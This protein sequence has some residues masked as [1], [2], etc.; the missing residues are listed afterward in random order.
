MGN[1]QNKLSDEKKWHS[2][3][4]VDSV[5]QSGSVRSTGSLG[6]LVKEK[7]RSWGSIRS[8]GSLKGWGARRSSSKDNLDRSHGKWP[9]PL[10]EGLFLPVFPIKG[11]VD[12]TDFE[13]LGQVGQGAFGEVL[14]VVKRDS[15]KKFAMKVLSKAEI[16]RG[17]AVQ[18]CKDEVTIQWMLG[19]H[20]FIVQIFHYWQSRNSLYIVFEYMSHGEM[21]E[22]WKRE[23]R[24]SEEVTR[25]YLS[26]L[27]L[28]LDYLHNS[29]VIYRDI[30]MENI[31]LDRN[32]NIRLVDF[33]LSKWLTKGSKTQ[34]ICGTLIYMAPEVL[35]MVQYDHRADWWSLGIL[36]YALLTGE[37]PIYGVKHHGKMADMVDTFNYSLDNSYS[38]DTRNLLSKLLCKSPDKRL[39]TLKAL[40]KQ[41]FFK[42]FCYEDILAKKISPR[43]ML[44]CEKY[45]R[46]NDSDVYRYPQ[47]CYADDKLNGIGVHLKYPIYGVKHH[48]KMAD[49]V[50]TFNYSLDNSYSKD[51]RNLL[52]KL[53]CK[54][55]DKRLHTLKA[56]KKQPFFKGFCYE[57]ILAKKISP[58]NMLR[59]EKYMR[60]N[61]SDVYR[62]TS[63]ESVM[64]CDGEPTVNLRRV[65]ST[66]TRRHIQTFESLKKANLRRASAHNSALYSDYDT[67][68]YNRSRNRSNIN[69]LYDEFPD[70]STRIVADGR[71]PPTSLDGRAPPTSLDG[72]APPTSL[73]GR[74][75]LTS[76]DAC[77]QVVV[78]SPRIIDCS[79][80]NLC[81]L[82]CEARRKCIRVVASRCIFL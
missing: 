69:Q 49:L 51:T 26:E 56:L 36:M 46:D 58:R 13:V 41:P 34:T 15:G 7:F 64:L 42:G 33:G 40:K 82:R 1:K 78:A 81:A 44:R 68:P 28:A 71:A 32:W 23:G 24:F 80:R 35:N 8:L 59:C 17:N 75:P 62:T 74:A 10:V 61:D 72:R 39:H 57:D 29:G 67:A 77:R 31:L 3:P 21:F 25:V 6:S 22:L 20:P 55:P 37:Y 11:N 76:L 54:S 4:V 52:S 5:S 18:Q 47:T 50:D 79:L 2:M 9:V 63:E 70:L 14:K 12:E 19:H 66:V 30:K 48:G 73:D 16:F 53:L 38:K 27:S 45:M 60:D 43:N 65:E